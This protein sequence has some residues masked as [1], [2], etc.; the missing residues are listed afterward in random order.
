LPMPSHVQ[1]PRAVRGHEQSAPSN[2]GYL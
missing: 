1:S 2:E